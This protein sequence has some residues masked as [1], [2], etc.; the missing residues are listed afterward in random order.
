MCTV[1]CSGA[2]SLVP[3]L[4]HN[5]CFLHS[6]VGY[7]RRLSSGKRL[8]VVLEGALVVDKSPGLFQALGD[9]VG[10]VQATDWRRLYGRQDGQ[11]RV[12]VVEN[13]SQSLAS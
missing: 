5:K 6:H 3:L 1:G 10:P 9:S 8:S 12:E 13:I 4:C 2:C 11:I 7:A